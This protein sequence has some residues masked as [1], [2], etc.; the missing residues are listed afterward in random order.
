MS[1]ASE[2][3]NSRQAEA[4]KAGELAHGGGG[5]LA[6][7]HAEYLGGRRLFT[8]ARARAH[9]HTRTERDARAAWHSLLS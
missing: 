4:K 5:L 7:F 3:L 8:R 2:Q 6:N 9:T 1:C